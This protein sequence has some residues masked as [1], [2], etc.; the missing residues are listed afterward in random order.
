M[1]AVI[2]KKKKKNLSQQENIKHSRVEVWE[3][4]CHSSSEDKQSEQIST[5]EVKNELPKKWGLVYVSD[6]SESKSGHFREHE[7]RPTIS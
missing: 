4:Y 5:C 3:F 6:M 1:G 2:A 7:F